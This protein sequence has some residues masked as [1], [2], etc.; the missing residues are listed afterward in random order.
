ME[1]DFK[2]AALATVLLGFEANIFNVSHFYEDIERK[3]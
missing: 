1:E 3:S 2:F